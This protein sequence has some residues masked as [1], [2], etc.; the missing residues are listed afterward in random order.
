M[1]PEQL[2]FAKTHEWVAIDSDAEGGPVAT[3]GIS[4]FAIEALTDLVYI[5][6]PNPET[7]V[8]AGESF[9]EIESVKAVS[10]IYAPVS[11]TIVE[12]NTAL[13]DALETLGDDAYG[14]GWIAKIRISP[15]GVESELMDYAS[16]QRMCQEEEH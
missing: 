8:T 4:A 6:L 12:V 5:E 13:P 9:S 14:A 15:D 11:G 1:N 16:Y 7:A 10:D 3:V 2:R